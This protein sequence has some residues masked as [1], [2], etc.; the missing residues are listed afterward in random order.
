MR[1][2]DNQTAEKCWS[3]LGD[4]RLTL[5]LISIFCYT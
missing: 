2:S 3:P 5:D 4:Y 1:D